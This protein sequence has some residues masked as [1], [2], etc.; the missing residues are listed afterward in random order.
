[1]PVYEIDPLTDPRWDKVT[2]CHPNSSIFHSSGW[3]R[4]LQVAYGYQPIA[5][6]LSPPDSDI[7]NAIVFCRVCSW[8]TGRR[9]VSLPFAD[10]C[11]PL[12]SRDEDIIEILGHACRTAAT[13]GFRFVEIRPVAPKSLDFVASARFGINETFTFHR[14]D[15]RPA[16]DDLFRS[17]HKDCIQR[18]IR[19]AERECLEH[20]EGRSERFLRVFFDLLVKTRRKHRIPPQP[21]TWFRDLAN[22]FGE[23]LQVRIA[24]K[25]H[26][27]VAAIMTLTWNNTLVYKYGCS[28]PAFNNLGG[29]P[30]LFWKAIQSAKAAGLS[31]FD[32]G[33]SDC[34]NP[35]LVSFKDHWG[36]TR[37]ALS[38][39]RHPAPE[40]RPLR[41]GWKR[42]AGQLF[43]R[44]PDPI[45]VTAGKVLY[46]HMG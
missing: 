6:T 2:L 35:G 36:A 44:L 31:W 42:L 28:D 19:R 23:R 24:L 41:A 16:V 15:L 11:E 10:H 45:L 22:C 39:W 38:Y 13:E 26:C 20:Q 4:A 40:R 14:V 3:L 12:V 34:D 9:L 29:T 8:A 25:G 17:F 21:I 18:K 30:L 46:R 43:K 33:R 27:P 5:Y 7:T 32:L 37:T 1:M